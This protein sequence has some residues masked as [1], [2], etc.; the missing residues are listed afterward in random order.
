[1]RIS[2]PSTYIMVGY[3]TLHTSPPIH[4]L[5]V[6]LVS[7]LPFLPLPNFYSLHDLFKGHMM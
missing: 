7:P 5:R 3:E 6:V 1:M 4:S 2:I